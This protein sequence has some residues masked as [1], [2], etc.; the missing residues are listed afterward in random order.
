MLVADR[1]V[2]NSHVLQHIAPLLPHL[3][4]GISTLLGGS[5]VNMPRLGSRSSRRSVVDTLEPVESLSS[6]VAPCRRRQKAAHTRAT[7]QLS[8]GRRAKYSTAA[9]WHVDPASTAEHGRPSGHWGLHRALG[10]PHRFTPGITS[11][12][13]I[14][15]HTRDDVMV[16]PPLP[17]RERALKRTCQ[18]CQHTAIIMVTYNQ[19]LPESTA[20]AQAGL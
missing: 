20:C 7:A 11:S 9:T 14:Q 17:K 2:S 13:A 16:R 1:F 5:Q 4:S 6:V 3:T 10:P 15:P 18:V 8:L 19:P 12:V